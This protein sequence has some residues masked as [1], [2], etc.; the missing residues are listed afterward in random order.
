MLIETDYKLGRKKSKVFF[1]HYIKVGISNVGSRRKS[2]KNMKKKNLCLQ[3]KKED[4]ITSPSNSKNNQD[5]C[6]VILQ[7]QIQTKTN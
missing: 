2:K 6:K 7:C 4:K 3:L 5:N 1:P